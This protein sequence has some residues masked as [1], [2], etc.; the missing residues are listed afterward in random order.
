MA[1]LLPSPPTFTIAKAKADSIDGAS[2][3]IDQLSQVFV[4]LGFFTVIAGILLI[5]NI[6]VMLAEERK[7]EM[8]VARALGMRRKNLVQSFVSEGL[9]YA[10]LSSVVGTFAGLLVAG[11]ILWGF[12]QVFPSGFGGNAFAVE[13]TVSDLLTGFSIGFL[14]TMATIGIASFRVS[15]LNIVRAIRDIPEP[16]PHR[17]TGRQVGIGAAL[18]GIG[19][20][21]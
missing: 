14:I 16:I 12:S 1:P 5:I 20:I 13:W 9:L 6:F 3:N 19:S 21:G 7:G 8:G 18:A 17:S 10:L 15:K 4:L 11:L 2:R